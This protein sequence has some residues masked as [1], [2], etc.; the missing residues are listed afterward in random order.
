M[1]SRYLAPGADYVDGGVPSINSTN[2][3][4]EGAKNNTSAGTADPAAVAANLTTPTTA[5][6]GAQSIGISSIVVAVSG[7][8]LLQLIN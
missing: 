2:T 5:S 1:M 8:I 3:F 7:I 6:S 4:F